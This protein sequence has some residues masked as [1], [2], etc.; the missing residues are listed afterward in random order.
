MLV[1]GCGSSSKTAPAAGPTPT[2]TPSAAPAPSPAGSAT[3]VPS[4]TSTATAAIATGPKSATCVNGWIQPAPGADFFKSATMALE[5]SQ[6][7]TGY[8]I[9]AV[10]YF[11]GPLPRGGEGAFYYV[12]VRDPRLSARV[13]LASGSG[14][15]QVAVA[16]SGTTGWKAGDWTGFQGNQAAAV[17]PPLPGK[18][19]GP[20]FDPV[21]AA[22]P[23]LAPSVAG[24]LAGT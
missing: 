24:C 22:T 6:G 15:S 19:A 13:L 2:V 18:W 12:D 21:S 23:L 8:T 11:A 17:H 7:G 16:K 3:P 10:R 5:Q 14:P 4:A 20:E 9:R 1:A